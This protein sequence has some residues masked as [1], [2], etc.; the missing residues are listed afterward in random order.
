MRTR[1][2]SAVAVMLSLVGSA[3]WSEGAYRNFKAAIYV[4]VTSTR[5]LADPKT[6]EQ[7]YQRM[8]GQVRFD[9]VYLEVY[10]SGQ[11]ADESSLESIK[12]FFS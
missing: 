8:A 11:F 3:A 5:Q 10:R 2:L 9:K 4:T 1:W 6:R 7:Q 12:K